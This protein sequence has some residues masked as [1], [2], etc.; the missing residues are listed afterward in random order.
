MHPMSQPSHSHLLDPTSIAV[1]STADAAL[2]S[3]LEAAVNNKTKPLGSLGML[4][5]LARQVGLIQR[6]VQPRISAPA[7]LVFAG[8]HGVDV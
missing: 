6:T 5:T 7:I 1:V 3:R 8:D 2:S 4:E